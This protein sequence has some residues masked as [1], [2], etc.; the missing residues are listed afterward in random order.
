MDVGV[1]C[2]DV[3]PSNNITVTFIKRPVTLVNVDILFIIVMTDGY[4]KA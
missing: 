2:S 4:P 3:Y 1:I